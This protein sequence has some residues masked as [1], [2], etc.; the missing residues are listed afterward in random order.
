MSCAWRVSFRGSKRSLLCHAKID[1]EQT[2]GI[3]WVVDSADVDRLEM[4][5]AELERLLLEE[6][7]A[8][9]RSLPS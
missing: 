6:V 8:K 2:D 7:R 9:Q 5:R 4:C 1:F 3:I